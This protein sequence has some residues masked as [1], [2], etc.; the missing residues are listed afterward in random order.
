M[1]GPEVLELD[2]QGLVC[3][4]AKPAG[5]STFV[6]EPGDLL[7]SE[8]SGTFASVGPHTPMERNIGVF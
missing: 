8:E 6:P 5:Y 1:G 7:E 3:L 2:P 4:L